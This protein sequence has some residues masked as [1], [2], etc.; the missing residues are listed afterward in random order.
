VVEP[1]FGAVQPVT[2]RAAATTAEPR[3]V[4]LFRLPSINVPSFFV[5]DV[6]A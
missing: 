2:A 1:V 6:D 4:N 5:P 3:H